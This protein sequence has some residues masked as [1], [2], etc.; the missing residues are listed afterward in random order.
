[1]KTK[2]ML[3]IL[4]VALTTMGFD[5]IN[6]D[7]SISVNLQGLTGT[8]AINPGTNLNFNSCTNT[9]NSSDYLDSD[10]GTIGG[11]RIY[12][13]KVS[14]I[15][16]Y[17]G[18]IANGRVNIIVNGT[19]TTVL[20]YSG[21]WAAFNTPQ[22]LISSPLITRNPGGV[23]ALVN[24]ILQ[25]QPIVICGLGTLS[26]PVTQIGDT[27]KVEVFGQVDGQL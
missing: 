1:M 4:I 7:A 21:S 16:A 19:T 3:V 15:G 14:T 12:D 6:D 24:A 26:Q 8:Y 20:S 18:N 22:S 2:F 25:R 5:C 13:I 9:I 27:V 23:Q 17:P 10:F 11:V